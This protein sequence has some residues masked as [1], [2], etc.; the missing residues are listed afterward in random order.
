MAS[1]PDEQGGLANIR[2]PLIDIRDGPLRRVAKPLTTRNLLNYGGADRFPRQLAECPPLSDNL[3]TCDG[4][5]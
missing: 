1:H 4:G 2:Q 3:L 5:L